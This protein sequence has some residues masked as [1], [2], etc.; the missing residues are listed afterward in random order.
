MVMPPRRSLMSYTRPVEGRTR[1]FAQ[2]LAKTLGVATVGTMRNA[3][4]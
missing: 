4:T 2:R 1:R 3:N